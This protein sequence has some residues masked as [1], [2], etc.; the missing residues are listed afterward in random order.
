M[1][2]KK[3]WLSYPV[4]GF[5]AQKLRMGNQKTWILPSLFLSLLKEQILNVENEKYNSS[6]F[7]G[8]NIK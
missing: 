2:E 5:T 4:G 8:K 6:D 7:S 3:F 1:E